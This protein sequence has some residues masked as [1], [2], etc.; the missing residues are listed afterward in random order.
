VFSSKL[1]SSLFFIFLSESFVTVKDKNKKKN[2]IEILPVKQLPVLCESLTSKDSTR[3]LLTEPDLVIVLNT[4]NL[5]GVALL[6]ALQYKIET[7]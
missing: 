5:V 1:N 7:F 4:G 3:G 2:D 6:G